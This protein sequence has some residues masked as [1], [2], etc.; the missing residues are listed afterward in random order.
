MSGRTV[1]P[2]GDAP[3]ALP[4]F[5]PLTPLRWSYLFLCRSRT[6]LAGP[7]SGFHGLSVCTDQKQA[8][9]PGSHVV[10]IIVTGEGLRAVV[11]RHGVGPAGTGWTESQPVPVRAAL[12]EAKSAL[13]ASVDAN[14][15]VA[16][17]AFV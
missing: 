7:Q 14:G 1:L 12:E 11:G 13:Q 10:S 17:P 16:P 6:V 9:P 2:L 5:N 4:F 8:I 3:A 15:R